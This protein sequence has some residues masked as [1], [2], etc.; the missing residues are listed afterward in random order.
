MIARRVSGNH[1]LTRRDA[2][3]RRVSRPALAEP[4]SLSC[5]VPRWICSSADSPALRKPFGSGADRCPSSRRRRGAA[6]SSVMRISSQLGQ[7]AAS[8]L[9]R[10]V[11]RRRARGSRS[12]ARVRHRVDR[13]RQRSPR[14]ARATGSASPSRDRSQRTRRLDRPVLDARVTEPAR[15]ALRP[16]RHRAA[17]HRA[18][19]RECERELLRVIALDATELAYISRAGS[20][21][22]TATTV[23]TPRSTNPTKRGSFMSL[24]H[25]IRRTV[26][27]HCAIRVTDRSAHFAAVRPEMLRPQIVHLHI[28]LSMIVHVVAWIAPLA[29][30]AGTTKDQHPLEDCSC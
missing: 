30:R 19:L 15:E 26:P 18:C 16:P 25:Y 17:R 12:R 13:C 29:Q 22:A 28:A 23:A 24:R 1:R 6:G 7:A 2:C 3:A 21:I 9:L 27:P 10:G 14:A 11:A 8:P 20:K 4:R 5:P